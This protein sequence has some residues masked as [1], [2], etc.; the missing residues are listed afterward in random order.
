MIFH[1]NAFL[2]SLHKFA[3]FQ[4]RNIVSLTT[5]NDAEMHPHQMASARQSVDLFE[6][7]LASKR[8]ICE[9]LEW[10][11]RWKRSREWKAS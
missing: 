4:E 9:E 6:Q 7:I 10:E 3:I 2:Q 1:P 5:D 8:V 11:F